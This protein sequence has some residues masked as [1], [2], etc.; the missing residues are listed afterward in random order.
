[1]A[2]RLPGNFFSGEKLKPKKG[3]TIGIVLVL[4]L[5]VGGWLIYNHY[6][7]HPKS[8]PSNTVVQLTTEQK[9]TI[10]TKTAQ[11]ALNSKDYRQ[12]VNSYLT[13]SSNSFYD[14]DYTKALSVLRECITKIPNKYL[15]WQ[16]Y[17]TVALTSKA[18]K[19][20]ALEK[21]SWQTTLKKAQ[22]PGSGATSKDISLIKDA[23]QGLK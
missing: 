5:G 9:N 4:V 19:N 14:K 3:L 7:N 13:A 18:A 20:M 6:N 11:G 16:F 21:S 10:L 1:M 8:K 15:D 22:T 2:S 12:A 17:E 23:L